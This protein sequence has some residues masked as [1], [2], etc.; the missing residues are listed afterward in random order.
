MIHER[1]FGLNV[2]IIPLDSLNDPRTPIHLLETGHPR[3]DGAWPGA[4]ED[5]AGVDQ[6]IAAD[7]RAAPQ[8][9]TLAD[10][11]RALIE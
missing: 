5:R 7:P 8:P 3:F 10:D 6:A 1:F 9:D 2:S 4:V 11:G